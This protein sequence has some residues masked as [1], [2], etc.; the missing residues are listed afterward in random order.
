MFNKARIDQQMLLQLKGDNPAIRKTIGI[1]Y[2]ELVWHVS[3]WQ[4][5]L[6]MLLQ[7]MDDNPAIRKMIGMLY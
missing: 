4:R 3:S 6:H 5:M 1:A 2:Q 7:L